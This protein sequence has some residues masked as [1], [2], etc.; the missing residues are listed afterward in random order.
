VKG[1]GAIAQ[2]PGAMAVGKGGLIIGGNVQESMI[3]QGD[4]NIA[5]QQ[6]DADGETTVIIQKKKR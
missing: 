2:G 1:D 4:G 5:S 3:I 6:T